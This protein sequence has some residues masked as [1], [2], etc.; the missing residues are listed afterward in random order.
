MALIVKRSRGRRV[1]S[2]RGFPRMLC[3]KS[4]LTA[5]LV[6]IF[7]AFFGTLALSAR[8]FPQ[9]YD[10]RYRVISNLLSPRDNPGHFRFAATGVAL[11][12][13]LMLPFFGYIQRQFNSITPRMA[14]VNTAIFTAGA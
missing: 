12:G 5:L 6:L 4:V 7:L 9:G 1:A 8:M 3:R 14:R 2:G 10:W 11:T 13:L